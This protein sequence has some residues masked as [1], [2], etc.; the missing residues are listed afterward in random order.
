M[1][2]CTFVHVIQTTI[3]I[4]CII[5]ITFSFPT[6]K[7]FMHE[8]LKPDIY[9]PDMPGYAHV[10]VVTCPIFGGEQKYQVIK[11]VK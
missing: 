1:Y 11:L 3:Y 9:H 4:Q 6:I 5:I 7:Q 8:K 10:E 2:T